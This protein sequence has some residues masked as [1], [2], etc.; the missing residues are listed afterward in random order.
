MKRLWIFL[1]VLC[2]LAPNAAWAASV[3]GT[4]TFAKSGEK[5]SRA[6]VV[7]SLNG[8]EKARVTTIDDGYY[9]VRNLPEGRYEVRVSHRHRRK[10]FR[11]VVVGPS[12][13]AFAFDFE[14]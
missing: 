7:F 6:L 2:L 14:I 13:G 11:D 5:L 12:G 10:T 1:F 8:Q 9:F 4:V 3:E